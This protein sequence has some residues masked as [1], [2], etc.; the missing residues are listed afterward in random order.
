MPKK[1]T[2]E[3]A[4]KEIVAEHFMVA[5][6]CAVTPGTRFREDLDADSLD[7]VELAM[8]LEEAFDIETSDED[9]DRLTTVEAAV[10]LVEEKM[11]AL[12]IA[13]VDQLPAVADA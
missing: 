13:I 12:K 3:A 2:V 5:D 11:A 7:I 9:A 4:V 8:L 1:R 6:E 10:E